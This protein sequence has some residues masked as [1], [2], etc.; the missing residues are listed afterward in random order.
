[1]FSRPRM[2]VFLLFIFGSGLVASAQ[3]TLGS[4]TGSVHDA[5]DAA[6]PGAR[7]TLHRIEN[8]IDRTVVTEANGSYTALNLE[9]GTYTIAVAAQGFGTNTQTNVHLDSRQQLRLDLALAAESVATTVQVDAS[10]AGTIN[11]D[12]ASIS[13]ALSARDVLDLPAN[14]RGAGS[15][16]PLNVIQTL[17]GVQ[18]DSGSFP[19]TPSSSPNPSIKFSIQGG[20]PSQSETTVDGISA[21]NQT[22]NNIQADAF[23][24][25][26]SIAEIRVDGVGNNAEYGQPGEITTVTKA[27]TNALHGSA[28]WYFQNRAFDA[29]PYGFTQATKPQKVAN[30]F[31]G[32]VGGP[33]Y[34]PYLY[35]GQDKSFFFATYEAL[36][37][38]Q[39][40]GRHLLVPTALMKQGD[41]SQETAA[42]TNPFAG[43]TYAGAK[44]PSINPSAAAFLSI[45]P[46]PNV[47]GFPTVQSAL[48][49]NN[50]YNY[51]DTRRNDIDSNQYDLRFDQNFGQRV[52]TFARYT[53]KT[54]NQTQ[55]GDLLVP[56]GTGFSKYHI[57]AAAA[58]WTITPHL[59]NE[60]RFGFTLEQDGTQN[61]FKRLGPDQERRT[62][63]N[64]SV[65]LQRIST[66]QL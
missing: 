12:D 9:A 24:S 58:N 15:T 53:N 28:F 3:S 48:A 38:P 26:E 30:D 45:Y 33:V 36:R 43:G 29:I 60:F 7:V 17:P 11:T 31:G 57:F 6:I 47:P 27:G 56:N 1:M 50:G 39:A 52:S 16:S 20:L 59:V 14:Y 18:P 49:G 34:L 32:S 54:I 64:E 4:I 2:I 13:A 66:R 61:P 40:V 23:P 25:A 22:A 41:F 46:D 42:L 8:N 44:L 51:V 21:Q 55:P 62:D 63:R 10:D 19:P 5:T 37:F 65:V 35:H